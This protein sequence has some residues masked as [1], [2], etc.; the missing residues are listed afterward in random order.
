MSRGARTKVRIDVTVDRKVLAAFRGE[1]ARRGVKLSPFVESR[2]RRQL[3]E[4]GRE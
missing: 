2:L 4:W 3:E 1:A